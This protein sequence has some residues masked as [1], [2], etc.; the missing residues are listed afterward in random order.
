MG[1][2]PLEAV[3]R[4]LQG[5]VARGAEAAADAESLSSPVPQDQPLG[6]AFPEGK[7]LHSP[8]PS[9][10]KGLPTSASEG[11]PREKD[12][13]QELPLPEPKGDQSKPGKEPRATG[14]QARAPASGVSC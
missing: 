14:Q 2:T 3:G 11:H 5:Q 7:D 8:N 6:G 13:T 9:K 1:K 4:P 12:A 10:G